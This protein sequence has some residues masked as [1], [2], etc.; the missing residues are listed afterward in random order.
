GSPANA[1]PLRTPGPVQATG[2]VTSTANCSDW[3]E[4]GFH[5]KQDSC[6]WYADDVGFYGDSFVSFETGFNRDHVQECTVEVILTSS[7]CTNHYQTT[8]CFLQAKQGG[9][10][11][12]PKVGQLYYW[13]F[14]RLKGDWYVQSAC[15]TVWTGVEYNSCPDSQGVHP[16]SPRVYKP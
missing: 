14:G 4:S 1:A 8:N 12:F 6:L 3:V 7:Y 13:G 9:T 2:T 10:W 11:Q 16:V 5:W 15:M